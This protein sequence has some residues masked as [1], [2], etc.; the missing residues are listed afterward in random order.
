MKIFICKPVMRIFV[1]LFGLLIQTN[2]TSQLKK[3]EYA[4]N[5]DPGLGNGLSMNLPAVQNIDSVFVL[6]VS[7]LPTGVHRLFYR[8]QDML[9]N[10]SIT[11]TTSF[12]K[13]PGSDTPSTITHLEYFFDADPGFGNG[14][15]IPVTEGN[16]V[17]DTFSFNVPDNGALTRILYVRGKDKMGAWSLLHKHI[18]DM[19]QLYRA[20]PDFDF[21]NFGNRYTFSDSTKNDNSGF[22]LWKF[23]NN[24]TLYATSPVSHPQVDLPPGTNNVR[25]I[26]GIGCRQDSI[27]RPV[28]VGKISK[29]FPKSAEAGGDAI[30]VLYGAG[31]D[32]NATVFLKRTA[33]PSSSL[34]PIKKVSHNRQ[35]LFTYFDLHNIVDTGSYFIE[36]IFSNGVK[37][38]LAF[39]VLPPNTADPDITVHIN[40]PVNI[41]GNVWGTFN[42]SLT[43]TGNKFAAGIPLFIAIPDEINIDFSSIPTRIPAQI[44]QEI[45]DSISRFVII[46]S[47]D[48]RPYRGKVYCIM[49]TGINGN[50]TISV[51]IRLL[52]SLNSAGDFQIYAW[53]GQ[54]MF[55]S[56]LKFFWGKCW[57]DLYFLVAG[58]VPGLGCIAGAYDFFSNAIVQTFGGEQSY[59]S[60]GE[61]AWGVA[62]AFISCIPGGTIVTKKKIVDAIIKIY[63]KSQPVLNKGVANAVNGTTGFNDC[64]ETFQKYF[65]SATVQRGTGRDPN[66][67]YGPGGYGPQ[68]Y[69]SNPGKVGYTVKFENLA[70]ATAAA[71]RVYVLDTLDKNKF[72]LSSFELSSITIGDSIYLLPP[73][74]NE[75]TQIVKIKQF[76]NI[77]V[78]LNIKLDT[79]SGILSTTYLS[80]DPVT[81]ELIDSVSLLGFLPP[82]TTAPSGEGSISYSV[83]IRNSLPSGTTVINR[84]GIVFDS[85]DTIVTNTWVNTID[86]TAPTI[87]GINTTLVNDTTIKIDFTSNDQHSGIWGNKIYMSINNGP[88]SYVYFGGK[89]SLRIIGQPDSSYTFYAIPV[90]NVGNT[91]GASAQANIKLPADQ[92]PIDKITIFPNPGKDAF[93]IKFKLPETQN[94]SVDLYN[95]NGQLVRK[96]FN[97]NQTGTVS[98]TAML[99]YLHTGVYLVLVK[100]DRGFKTSAKLV[101]AR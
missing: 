84:A 44:S 33:N 83:K 55:G 90:D 86:I 51:P 26:R 71:Q 73:A 36:V 64:V 27:Q 94:I 24:N 15:S 9:D 63:T 31:L 77:D 47:I 2:A 16:I 28:T 7:G 34:S 4:F 91:G 6:N 74:I 3:I 32:T 61:W 72:D 101:I 56:A 25:L 50:Q 42:I 17:S 98:L 23:F 22:Y 67:I 41:R 52:S 70:T 37:D 49:L 1:F 79:V 53:A 59:A 45:K 20:L 30:I 39:R 88:F 12:F 58:F 75:F 46:D 92:S 11:N 54:R 76:N 78:L 18:I 66:E 10:W 35:Q 95:M 13:F 81:K 80:V 60:F 8:V 29:Y 40:G 82:N 38:T 68:R 85:N 87:S 96:I 89:D 93:N 43:N 48:G 14:T 57:D 69:I 100:G 5:N 65:G 99:D 21:V 97:G 19:C 62:S